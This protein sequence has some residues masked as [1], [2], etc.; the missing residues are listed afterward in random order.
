MSHQ[1]VVFFR[2]F[3]LVL[4]LIMVAGVAFFMMAQIASGPS[5]GQSM[6]TRKRA[7]ASIEERIKPIGQVRLSG[8]EAPAAAAP[9]EAPE[10]AVDLSTVEPDTAKG[11]EV[12]NTA[13][14]ACHG[15]GVAGA[16]KVGDQ[17]SWSERIGKGMDTLVDN[18]INGFQGSAGMMPAKGGSATLGDADVKHAV[19][20]MVEESQ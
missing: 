18:A 13:C 9:A 2:N 4:L 6:E 1:D 8:E 3:G 12:Y 14:V 17:A 11:Q 16:P 19:A 15:T 10:A 20:F 5:E 7:E